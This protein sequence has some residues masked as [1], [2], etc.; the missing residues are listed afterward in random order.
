MTSS[1]AGWLAAAHRGNRPVAAAY[2]ARKATMIAS[3]L[4]LRTVDLASLGA[5]ERSATVSRCFP[6]ATVFWLIVAL[7]E[8][9]QA[10]V[11]TLYCSTDGLRR[12]GATV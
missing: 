6:F 10:L 3:A 1:D 12:G 2:A 4:M 11:T 5:V 8:R 7:R 9:S